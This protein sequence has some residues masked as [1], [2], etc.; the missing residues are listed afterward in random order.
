MCQCTQTT[1]YNDA[2]S[3]FKDDEVLWHCTTMPSSM[4]TALSCSIKLKQMTA[5]ASQC[6]DD[7]LLREAH[8]GNGSCSGI[9]C[10]SPH[11]NA[12]VLADALLNGSILLWPRQAAERHEGGCNMH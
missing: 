3:D 11:S 12:L 2:A 5:M 9:P 7:V 6:Q 8:T 1:R 10:D 4:L